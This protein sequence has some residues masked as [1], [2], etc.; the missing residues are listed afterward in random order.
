MAGISSV[1][2]FVS[3]RNKVEN[4]VREFVPS[5]LKICKD[6]AVRSG[7]FQFCGVR[8]AVNL[9]ELEHEPESYRPVS[10]DATCIQCSICRTF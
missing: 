4:I 2:L 9:A 10:G 6:K 8:I 1:A 3:V 5:K 7:P